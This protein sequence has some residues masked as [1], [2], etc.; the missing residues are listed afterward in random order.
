MRNWAA[1]GLLWGFALMTD[2]ALGSVAPF[3]LGWLAWRASKRRRP[4]IRQLAIAAGTIALAVAPWTARNYLT[5]HRWIPLRSNFPFELWLGNNEVLDPHGRDIMARVT[6]YGEV[7]RYVQL[8]ETAF[9]REKW[10]KATEFMR[11]HPQLE[12]WLFRRRFT[13]TWTGSA[14]PIIDFRDASSPFIQFLYLANALAG[15]GAG[16]GILVLCAKRSQYAFPVSMFPLVFPG[17]YYVT[18]TSLR[19]RYPIDPMVM[20]LAAAAVAA[21]VQHGHGAR[22]RPSAESNC[23]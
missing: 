7:R 23:R 5:F 16:A 11:T 17:L 20:L 2:A 3:L 22:E 14:D 13:A 10:Q 12:L 9:M 4:W 1:Y 15:I 18:H 8:G 6:A 21:V 19:Y